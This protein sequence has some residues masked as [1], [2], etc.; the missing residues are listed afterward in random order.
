MLAVCAT[1]AQ[2]E[3]CRLAL[4]LAMDVSSSVDAAEDALQRGGL[5]AA[6]IAP[7]V[8]TAFFAAPQ[9]V[10]LAVYEWSGR[11][12]QELLLD[13]R[14][15][16]TPADLLAAA[17]IIARSERSQTE[18]PT[19]LGHALGY[20]AGLLDRAPPCLFKTLDMAGDGRN[21]EGYGPR[22]AYRHFD[23]GSVTVN[24]LV[25]NGADF[26]GE[27]ELIPYYREN[28]LHGPGAFL[29][30]AQGFED[31]ERAMRRKLERE[32]RPRVIGALPAPH[33][34]GSPG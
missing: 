26:E 30:I 29:E 22:I 11:W 6:L 25:V 14:L 10:A 19:A 13:W 17:E 2:A 16:K 32:L 24:G 20:G 18:S 34:S 28:V 9:P 1:A 5:A 27:I 7:E 12:N 8:Q 21:N 31:Y 4:V 33:N 3:D 15:I 23:Y